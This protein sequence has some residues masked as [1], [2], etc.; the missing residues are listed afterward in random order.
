MSHTTTNPYRD[1]EGSHLHV[2]LP[3]YKGVVHRMGKWDR[4]TKQTVSKCGHYRRRGFS[5]HIHGS[6]LNPENT[7][8]C[9][10]CWRGV[11]DE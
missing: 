2:M 11:D 1:P 8:R 9:G 3:T 4:V 5:G 10:L 6:F 7:V